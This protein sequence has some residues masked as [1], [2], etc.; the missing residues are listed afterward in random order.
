MIAQVRR[1][2]EIPAYVVPSG[3][4]LDPTLNDADPHRVLLKPST[5]KTSCN[6]YTPKR[7]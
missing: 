2:L 6:M 1:N 3:H 5:R 4:I 7:G